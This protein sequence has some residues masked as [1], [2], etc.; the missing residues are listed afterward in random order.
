AE[1]KKRKPLNQH[2]SAASF[3][4]SKIVCGICK[5]FFGPK[6]WHSASIYKRTVW[7]CN[8]KYGGDCKCQSP[9]LYETDI[10]RAF[11]NAFNRMYLER[12][13]LK[14]DYAEII[15]VL[16]DTSALDKEIASRQSELDVFNELIRKLIEENAST[17]LQQ[18]DY[19]RRYDELTSRYQ[20]AQNRIKKTSDE[21]QSRAAKRYNISRFLSDLENRA[22]LLTEFD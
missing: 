6:L 5:G 16:T 8:H 7:R 14:K 11:I 9:H 18:D 3:F 2:Q 10:Q 15:G 21:K 1:L 13:S 17:P 20:A 12:E 22:G 19:Y 4:S